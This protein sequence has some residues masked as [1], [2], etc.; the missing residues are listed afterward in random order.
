M[1]LDMHQALRCHA[2]SK[3]S[4]LRCQAPA[5]R[6]SSVCRMH[7]AGG[8]APKGNRNALKHGDFTAEGL[9]LTKEVASL[10]RIARETLAAIK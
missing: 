4:G 8:G 6:G 9:A 5:V 2:K 1:L 7:G 3:R 10:A